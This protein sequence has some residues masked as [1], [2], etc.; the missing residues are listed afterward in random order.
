MCGKHFLNVSI[1][2]RASLA[3]RHCSYAIFPSHLPACSAWFGSKHYV[4]V[5][6]HAG[7]LRQVKSCR[8]GWE[9]WWKYGMHDIVRAHGCIW[10]SIAL[11]HYTEQ[12]HLQTLVRSHRLT[13]DQQPF[14]VSTVQELVACKHDW[15]IIN[16]KQSIPL[17]NIYSNG[18]I[19][20]SSDLF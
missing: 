3:L 20:S 4:F 9:M 12:K 19:Y 2:K 17:L 5:L 8:A 13:S 16:V 14:S 10:F 15:I 1:L 18:T 11:V 6:L 7:L